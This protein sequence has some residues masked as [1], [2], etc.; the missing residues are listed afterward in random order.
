[1]TACGI[2]RTLRTSVAA[3]VPLVSPQSTGRTSLAVGARVA[4]NASAIGPVAGSRW[5]GGV[6]GTHIQN[7]SPA[8]RA[9][10]AGRTG[11]VVDSLVAPV[12]IACSGVGA[13]DGGDGICNAA[14]LVISSLAIEVGRTLSARAAVGAEEPGTAHATH[15]IAGARRRITVGRA[16]IEGATQAEGTGR[17]KLALSTR[18]LVSW[19][20]V[21][22][23]ELRGS[24][25]GREVLRTAH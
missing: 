11:L 16:L 9:G 15:N 18:E 8:P 10:R 12:A 17:T 25:I 14:R 6:G 21:T 4:W 5:G 24:N 3:I 7:S 19:L 13:L 1:M 2:Q 20:A 22:V 23:T